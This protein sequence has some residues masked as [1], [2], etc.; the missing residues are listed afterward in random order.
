[1][2]SSQAQGIALNPRTGNLNVLDAGTCAVS[3]GSSAS[4]FV[5]QQL[6][7]NAGASAITLAGTFSATATV[8]LSA[9]GGT[10]WVTQSTQKAVGTASYAVAG[11]NYICV[12]IT[13]YTSGSANVTISS[14]LASSNIATL[15]ANGAVSNGIWV[16]VDDWLVMDITFAAAQTGTIQYGFNY[17]LQKP[18]GSI[19]NNQSLNTVTNPVFGPNYVPI[20]ISASG[21]LIGAT[22]QET[23]GSFIPPTGMMYYNLFL[24][25]SPGANPCSAPP[26]TCNSTPNIP[27]GVA[28]IGSP[29]ALNFPITWSGGSAVYVPPA[30]G[31]GQIVYTTIAAGAGVEASWSIPAQTRLQILGIWLKLTTSATVA[32]RNFYISAVGNQNY[33]FIPSPINQPASTVQVYSF[34]P[35]TGGVVQTPPGAGTNVIEIPMGQMF[36]G[37]GGVAG[38]SGG[39][40]CGGSTCVIATNTT[41]LQAGDA[42]IMIITY[43]QWNDLN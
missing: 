22:I 24:M 16:T 6:P 27:G 41:N 3:S 13:A 15:S 14:S 25:N 5:V 38:A 30:A 8:R 19:S 42:Y 23:G 43:L 20:Q 36:F 18:D 1:V 34:T 29:I 35:G 4:S 7:Q 11:F 40:L 12:D 37:S 33:P 26:T 39:S 10:T 9:D 21:W 2:F 28:L 31:A 17:R 32:N